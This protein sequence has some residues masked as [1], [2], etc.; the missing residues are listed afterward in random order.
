MINKEHVPSPSP[1]L[2]FSIDILFLS[3]SVRCKDIETRHLEGALP[4][5]KMDCTLVILLHPAPG[6]EVKKQNV[7]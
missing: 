1:Q 4:L 6:P 2:A 5:V 3:S 7:D